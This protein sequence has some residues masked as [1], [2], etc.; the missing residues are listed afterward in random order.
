MLLTIKDRISFF[1]DL[2]EEDIIHMAKSIKFIRPKKDA[3]I[4]EQGSYGKEI[5]FVLKGIV[6]IS[7]LN[8]SEEFMEIATL[9]KGQVFGEMAMINDS[10]SAKA[11]VKSDESLILQM[12][13]IDNP[14]C[15]DAVA[16]AKMYQNM[17]SALAKKLI[18]SNNQLISFIS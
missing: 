16:Y 5:Y 17:L 8:H 11:S 3:V 10:R 1:K 12:E 18:G 14:S 2:S 13:L 15:D 7:S 9:D 6:S 4:F